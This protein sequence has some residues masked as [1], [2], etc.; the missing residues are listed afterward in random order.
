MQGFFSAAQIVISVMVLTEYISPKYRGFFLTIKSATFYWGIWT[1]NILGTFCHWKKIGLAGIICASFTVTTVFVWPESPY[2]LASKQRFKECAANHRWL[3]GSDEESEK[4]LEMLINTQ[5]E[6]VENCQ[7]INKS[8]SEIVKQFVITVRSKDFY[9]PLLIS[10]LTG[11][12]LVLSGKLVC[13][14]YAIDIIKKVTGN[15][16]T[17]YTGMLVLDGITVASMY[18]GCILSKFLK[19]REMLLVT[20]SIGVLFLYILSLYLYLIRLSVISENSSVS[21]CLLML[22]SIA[23]SCGPLIMSSAVYCELIPLRSRNLAVCIIAL[24]GKLIVA[25]L[26]K[27][28]PYI[29]K[30]FGLHGT[31]LFFGISSTIVIIYLYKYLPETKDK[32]LQEIANN[33]AGVALNRYDKS[34]GEESSKFV[35]A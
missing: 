30:L 22:F 21:V 34:N 13:T 17:A 9:K 10:I 5:K 20:S 7:S 16:S 6:Y 25:V 19:R 18:I 23:I 28:A 29:F 4:E 24:I 2:W 33:I 15:E 14:V 26:L 11:L 35:N 32:T 1:A 12:L 27:I 8:T 31:F 3:K